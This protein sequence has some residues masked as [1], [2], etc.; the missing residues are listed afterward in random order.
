MSK[1]M[2]SRGRMSD[3]APNPVDVYVGQRLLIRRKLLKLSQLQL[4]ELTALTFQQIQKYE[5]GQNR[6]SCSRLWD[7]AK[8]LGVEVN[9]FFEG[10]K[11]DIC[12]QSPRNLQ[13]PLQRQFDDDNDVIDPMMRTESIILL[14]AY[15]RI[16]N[17]EVAKGLYDII[18]NL[19]CCSVE[20]KEDNLEE[21]IMP[22]PLRLY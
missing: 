4:A 9:Y 14:N 20:K 12:A 18:V 22:S 6:I 13:L 5:S 15:Y 7:F 2:L 16:A 11:A 8:V 17:R 3:G 10:M 1:R 19:A 21:E